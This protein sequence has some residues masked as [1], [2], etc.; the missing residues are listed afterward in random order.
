MQDLCLSVRHGERLGLLGA[1]GAGKT[2]TLGLLTRQILPTAGDAFVHGVSILR[3]DSPNQASAP[4]LGYC[5]QVDPLLD[6]MTAREQLALFARLKGVPR[7][8]IAPAVTDVLQ[9]VTITKEMSYRPS[10]QYS[11]GNKRKLA[12]GIAL[13]GGVS[14]ILLDEPSSGMVGSSVYVK[15]SPFVSF[16]QIKYAKHSVHQGLGKWF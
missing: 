3:E 12:L 8:D 15:A 4:G 14:A 6:L 16:F 1:N 9:R 13:V 2:T 5:P 10:G 7:Q 11:G